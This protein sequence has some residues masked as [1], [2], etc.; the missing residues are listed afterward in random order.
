MIPAHRPGEEPGLSKLTSEVLF[1]C[2]WQ[3]HHEPDPLPC[4]RGHTRAEVEVK[5]G[6]VLMP[7]PLGTKGYNGGMGRRC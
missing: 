5:E 7:S 6:L 3:R 2:L 4:V 1:Y